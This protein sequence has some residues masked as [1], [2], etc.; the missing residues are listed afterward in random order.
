M[1]HII[2]VMNKTFKN[3]FHLAKQSYYILVMFE[4]SVVAETKNWCTHQESQTHSG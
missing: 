2:P 3:K 1:T 4:K